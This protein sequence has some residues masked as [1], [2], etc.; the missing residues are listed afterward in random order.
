MAAA[1]MVAGALYGV[2]VVTL[3]AWAPR[4]VD[5]DAVPWLLATLVAG[6]G[7]VAATPP[8][9]R[10]HVML[11]ASVA[12]WA[13]VSPAVI[14]FGVP[15]ALGFRAIVWSRWR[16]AVTVLYPVA[17]LIAVLVAADAAH[18]PRLVAARPWLWVIAHAFA[19]SW[20]LRALVVWHE[21]RTGALRPT[22]V[23]VLTYFFLAPFAVVPPYML[24]LPRLRTVVDGVRQFDPAVVRTAVPW[25]GYG[26]AVQAAL[27]AAGALAVDPQ[28]HLIAALRAGAWA[29]ALP[30]AIVVYPVRAVFEAC[31]AGA[32]VLGLVRACGVPM[33][34]AFDR[35]LLAR[36]VAEWW[37]RY[38]T[39]FRGL[40]VDLFWTPTALRLRR[41]PVLAGYAGCAAVFLLGSVPLH[42]P[43]QAALHA[44]PWSFPW[45]TLAESAI[46][47]IVVG[48]A[49]ALERRRRGRAAAPGRARAWLER[50]RTWAVVCVAILAV[51]YQIDYRVRIAPYERL[52]ARARA[53]ASAADA[54]ALVAP[55]EAAVDERPSDPL[56]RVTYAQVLIVAGEPVRGLRQLAIAAAFAT[57]SELADARLALRPIHPPRS[58]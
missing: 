24:A 54:A 16:P 48:T 1:V 49:L 6:V 28:A 46:M 32:L 50:G 10:L 23:E 21:A 42:W 12:A 33:L 52:A 34:P 30:L 53:I 38:N 11:I 51:G 45:S 9:W 57:R 39:H 36:S 15:W 25:L 26:L 27:A 29:R 5:D 2:G 3:V 43:K 41:H 47:T 17:T 18:F 31:G 14:A 22:G 40:L 19:I 8:R 55:L 20:F 56:R 37:R 44:S 4:P 35:P 7:A 58:P 13:L